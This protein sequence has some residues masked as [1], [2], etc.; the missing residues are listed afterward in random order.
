MYMEE[1]GKVIPCSIHAGGSI[2]L[3]KHKTSDDI[4]CVLSGNG[5]AICDGQEEIISAGVC[6][7][8]KKGSEHSIM[9]T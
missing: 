9:K 1:Q 4:N 7:I 6:Y 2:D 3:H 8:P 5:K